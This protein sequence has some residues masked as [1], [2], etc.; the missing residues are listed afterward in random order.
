[1]TFTGSL[2]AGKTTL[3]QGLLRHAG[4]TGAIQS[5]T[6]S[7]VHVYRVGEMRWYHFDLYRLPDMHAFIDAG[8]AEYLYRPGTKA[9]IEWPEIIEPL[10]VLDACHV[11]IEYQGREERCLQV[12]C[13]GKLGKK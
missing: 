2:G 11:E 1:M 6:F 12:Q 13:S 10:V 4:V 5:P 3:I 8:F 9:L 7:Y